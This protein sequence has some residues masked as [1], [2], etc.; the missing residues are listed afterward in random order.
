MPSNPWPLLLLLLS[1]D[2]LGCGN[3]LSQLDAP[4]VPLAR[5]NVEVDVAAARLRMP[6]SALWVGVAWGAA[7]ENPAIC[8]VAPNEPLVQQTCRDP[9][10]FRP[11]VI[12]NLV[13]LDPKG[14][15]KITVDLFTPPDTVVSVG[16]PDGRIAYASVAVI[17]GI[18][19]YD[20][21][22][23]SVTLAPPYQLAAASFLS[24][25]EL[26]RRVVYREG[27]FDAASNFY[28]Y[29][30]VSPDGDGA[31]TFLDV[32]T[33]IWPTPVLAEET[34][35]WWCLPIAQASGPDPHAVSEPTPDFNPAEP[36]DP[37]VDVCV[38]HDVLVKVTSI[39]DV[40][41]VSSCQFLSVFALKGCSRNL[42]C[43]EP[44]WDITADPPW[45]WPCN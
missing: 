16:G 3:G 26:Q 34:D 45:W 9:Y 17:S 44:E 27:A 15:G 4:P 8:Y 29:V 25:A 18:E 13:E 32:G 39:P 35:A 43:A 22:K 37:T 24:L 21:E 31:C 6:N 41:G 30:A 5:L 20:S 23:G 19:T 1:V 38:G 7:W 42:L 2:A 28:P 11:G 10:L 40:V 14:N 33:T 12:D 36:F